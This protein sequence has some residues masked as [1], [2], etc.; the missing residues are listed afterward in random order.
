MSTATATIDPQ[1]TMRELLLSYPGARRAL[2]K[3][4]HIGGCASCGF[5]PSETLAEVCA[6]NG[7]LPVDEVAGHILSSHETDRQM[8]IEPAEAAALVA[9]G[10]AKLLD[11]RTREEYD[12]VHI[13]GAIFFTQQ[14]MHEIGGWD[15]S[16]LL[17]FVDHQ[18]ARTLDATAY[19][20][21][22]G[23]ENV[24]AL[25]G[26]IDAWSCEVDPSLARYEIEN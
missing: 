21:G 25:R 13:E 18:G 1:L 6:R 17:I 4:Y 9:K 5:Q 2:F 11:V 10:E 16:K 19:F 26:G 24:R 14:L 12:A 20:V 8:L 23:V 7:N 22:H 3:G 15:R